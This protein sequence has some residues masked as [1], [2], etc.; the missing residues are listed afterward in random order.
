MSRSAICDREPPRLRG[1]AA[2]E[3]RASASASERGSGAGPLAPT[4]LQLLCSAAAWRGR[5]RREVETAGAGAARNGRGTRS[6]RRTE[7]N[8][9]PRPKIHTIVRFHAMK[10]DEA[11]K[12]FEV[13]VREL[14]EEE[15]F[16][17]VGFDRGDGWRR[18]G[19]GA[20]MH[21]RVL[22]ARC[23]AHAGYRCGGPPPGAHPDRGLDGDPDRPPRRVRRA[24]R[25]APGYIEELKSTNLSVEGVRP[26]G[27]AFERD[28]RQLLAYCS[29]WRRLG[30]PRVTGA[31]V[32]VDI[33]TGEE[34]SIPGSLR[35]ATRP[36]ATSSGGSPR[37]SRSGGPRRPS[38]RARRRRRSG[39][40]SRTPRRAPCSSRSSKRSRPR[41]P[42]ASTCSPRRR[43][44]PARPPPRSTPRWRAGLTTGPAGRLPHVQDAP[45]EDGRLS[46]SS[47]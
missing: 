21:P 22:A 46:R 24:R 44:A 40:P 6:K 31:L 37:S 9:T 1:R 41:S 11:S 2:A 17:R 10:F 42:R 47:P 33:E 32:Y 19:L 13:S 45:A 27:Y 23:D 15:G 8:R 26:A 30:H 29:L 28:R 16:R 7:W 34:V 38:A 12:T 5:D 20:Q 25:R 43:R 39:S 14:A 3:R 4:E 36:T 18:L 35:R